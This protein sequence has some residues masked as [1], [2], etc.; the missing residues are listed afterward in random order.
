M[1]R[2]AESV[3]L[4]IKRHFQL[5]ELEIAWYAANPKKK[6]GL[7]ALN[8]FRLQLLCTIERLLWAPQS[9]ERVGAE[10]LADILETNGAAIIA[11]EVKASLTRASLN[12]ALD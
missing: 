6:G 3:D 1:A 7:F 2:S 5:R 8:G 11:T 4:A 9:G 12:R 10:T